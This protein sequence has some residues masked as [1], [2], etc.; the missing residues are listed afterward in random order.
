[1]PANL[2]SNLFALQVCITLKEITNCQEIKIKWPNDIMLFGKKIAGIL[3][4]KK[5]RGT[6]I[7]LGLNFYKNK[8]PNSTYLMQCGVFF[9]R[10]FVLVNIMNKWSKFKKEFRNGFS[11]EKL[12]YYERLWRKNS[13]LLNKKVSMSLKDFL[14]IGKAADSLLEG[15]LIIETNSG[16]VSV[17]EN[18]YIPGS[19]VI[20]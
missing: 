12:P 16:I 19:C 2:L 13:F 20:V 1:M 11:K 4:E 15:E 6:L 3:I 10:Q 17:S 18:D 8:M 9:D 5:E 14:I 7:G